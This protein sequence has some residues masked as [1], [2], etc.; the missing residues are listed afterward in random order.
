MNSARNL[1]A[2]K[3]RGSENGGNRTRVPIHTRSA[4]F[5]VDRRI[6]SADFR[7]KRFPSSFTD[8]IPRLDAGNTLPI[9]PRLTIDYVRGWWCIVA[10]TRGVRAMEYRATSIVAR[11]F[12]SGYDRA[13]DRTRYLF[14][15]PG[16]QRP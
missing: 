3:E 9:P 15:V 14:S 1:D 11:S 13:D 5:G 6:C 2:K 12:R 7:G 10:G 4:I 8:E 16:N